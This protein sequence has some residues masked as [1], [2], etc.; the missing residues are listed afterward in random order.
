L[1]TEGA[2]IVASFHF[3]NEGARGAGFNGEA[4]G[5]PAELALSDD[6]EHG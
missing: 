4:S 2:V 3:G 1:A 6:I 5:E